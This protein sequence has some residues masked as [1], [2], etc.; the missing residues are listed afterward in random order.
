[1]YRILLFSLFTLFMTHSKGQAPSWSWVATGGGTDNDDISAISI[2]PSGNI[3]VCGE[4]ESTQ[5]YVGNVTLNNSTSNGIDTDFFLTK[6]DA[7]GNLKWATSVGGNSHEW[8]ANVT[9]DMNGN[10]FLGGLAHSFQF[11]VGNTSLISAGGDDH[12]LVKYDSSG[13]VIWAKK[14]G[15]VLND[16]GT[17]MITDANGNLYLTGRFQS[18]TFTL[19]TTTLTNTGGYDGFLTKIDTAGNPV[20][21]ISCSANLE[22]SLSHIKFDGMGNLLIIGNYTGDSLLMGSAF[23]QNPDTGNVEMFFVKVDTAGNVVWM[24]SMDISGTGVV[25]INDMGVNIADEIFICGGFIGDSMNVGSSTLINTGIYGDAFVA[26]Y[27]GSGNLQWIKQI[28]EWENEFANRLAINDLTGQLVV[29]GFYESDSLTFGNYVIHNNVGYVDFWIV[30]YDI[31]TGMETWVKSEGYSYLDDIRGLAFNPSGQ[32]VA[33]GTFEDNL[34]L[35]NFL[36]TDYGWRDY[37]VGV[38]GTISGQTEILNTK[39]DIN[40]YPNPSSGSFTVNCDLKPDEIIIRNAVG[41]L[42]RVLTPQSVNTDFQLNTPGV[43]ILQVRK[44]QSFTT[45][46]LVIQN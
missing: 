9:T 19:G 37:F 7:A 16:Y 6:Y 3:Y 13:N 39:P 18:P 31:V 40:I 5:M 14:L 32:L 43:Y 44:D 15:G 41:Q 24:K 35:G 17:G 42:I 26:A 20:W 30:S 29:C 38:L 34:Q 46:K 11:Q 12:L 8:H 4:Y 10:V 22:A 27:D 25:Y 1:M 23:L 21:A 28:R 2:D 45:S 33:A 36:L